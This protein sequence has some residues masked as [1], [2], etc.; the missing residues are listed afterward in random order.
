VAHFARFVRSHGPR[1]FWGIV[2]IALV[3]APRAHAEEAPANEETSAQAEPAFGLQSVEI[4]GERWA[5][6]GVRTT[7][8]FT[9]LL[10]PQ[11]G[12]LA[13]PSGESLRHVSLQLSVGIVPWSKHMSLRA[14]GRMSRVY[15][16]SLLVAA[17]VEANLRVDAGALGHHVA[18]PV[19]ALFSWS[20]GRVAWMAGASLGPRWDLEPG[21]VGGQFAAGV[22]AALLLPPVAIPIFVEAVYNFSGAYDESWGLRASVV[23]PIVF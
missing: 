16:M 12:F 18:F 20:V 8:R 19:R 6:V 13:S 21:R 10:V 15:G 4:D 17:G 5:A 14:P 2:V 22:G 7:R 3:T 23:F 9:P 1:S 11:V